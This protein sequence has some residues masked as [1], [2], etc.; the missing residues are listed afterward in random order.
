[1]ALGVFSA[2]EKAD[3]VFSFVKKARETIDSCGPSTKFGISSYAILGWNYP[4]NLETLGQDV[5]RFAPNDDTLFVAIQHPGEDRGS[6]FEK[7]STRWPDFKDGM[8]PRPSI[9][10]ITRKGGGPIGS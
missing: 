8:P 2:Q 1:M 7:P 6:T 4:A 5:V 3:K 9:V 10:A